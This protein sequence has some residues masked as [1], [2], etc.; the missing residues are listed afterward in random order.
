[1]FSAVVLAQ[2]V[3]QVV[4]SQQGLQSIAPGMAMVGGITSKCKMLLRSKNQVLLV[5]NSECSVAMPLAIQSSS[6]SNRILQPGMM[7]IAC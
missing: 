4:Q 6:N 1:M 3:I 5:F 7:P 2:V